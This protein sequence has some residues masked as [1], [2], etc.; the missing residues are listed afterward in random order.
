MSL[1]VAV[2]VPSVKTSLNVNNNDLAKK[3]NDFSFKIDKNILLLQALEA[4]LKDIKINTVNLLVS[5][6]SEKLSDSE[7]KQ[8]SKNIKYQIDEYSSKLKEIKSQ[9]ILQNAKIDSF[10]K[11]NINAYYVTNTNESDYSD[12]LMVK[13]NVNQENVGSSN[14]IFVDGTNV[15]KNNTTLLISEK[16]HKVYL[17]YFEHEIER[18]LEQFPNQY[19]SFEEVVKKEFIIPMKYYSVHSSLARFRETYSLIRDREGKSVFESMK[20]A[21]DLMFKYELNPAIIAACKTQDEL[22]NYLDC[23]D[24]KHIEDFKDFEIKYDVNPIAVK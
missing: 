17:P 7:C 16:T 12:S 21:F 19:K 10:I 24:N 3:V 22:D 11:N 4:S 23:L 13:S 14:N 2:T 18:Y 1:S 5:V 8:Q 15:K 20:Q 6:E 9:I